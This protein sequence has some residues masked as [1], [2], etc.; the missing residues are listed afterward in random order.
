MIKSQMPKLTISAC[1]FLFVMT[2]LTGA[3]FAMGPKEHGKCPGNMGYKAQ[4]AA[5][6]MQIAKHL[7]R[8]EMVAKHQAEIGLTQTQQD[9]IKAK[10]QE[11]EETL[12]GLEVDLDAEI[13]DFV[14]L[15][16]N[17]NVDRDKAMTQLDKVLNIESM[18]KKER[19]G[20]AI[21]VKNELT[22]D[23]LAQLEKKRH[24]KME[25]FKKML[26]KHG[27]MKGQLTE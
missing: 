2:T 25:R 3:A 14:S 7:V 6:S 11:S 13:E 15:L 19:L 12:S 20:L 4:R 18:I 1:L 17:D 10:M 24:N 26:Q 23:Q 5:V 21:A 22:P 9:A 27:D 16:N 8:P